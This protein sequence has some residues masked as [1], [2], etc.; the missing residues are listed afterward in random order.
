MK[1]KKILV[2]EDDKVTQ[3]IMTGVLRAAGYEVFTA[4]DAVAAVQAA[5]TEDPDLITLDISLATPAPDATWDGFTVGGWLR[6]LNEGKQGEQGKQRPAIVVISAMDPDKV[7]EK[8]AE[9]GAFTFLPKPVEKETLLRVVAE[10][11]ES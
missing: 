4:E 3:K 7:I 1:A 11:L 10:A 8:A 6:R 2:V 9:I 5:R